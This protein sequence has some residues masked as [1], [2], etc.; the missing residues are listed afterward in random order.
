MFINSDE[1]KEEGRKCRWRGD[2]EHPRKGG[3][4]GESKRLQDRC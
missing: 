1:E 4:I 2:T 3:G